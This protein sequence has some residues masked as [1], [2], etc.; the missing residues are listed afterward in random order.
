VTHPESSTG[1]GILL[2]SEGGN[3]DDRQLELRDYL[4][5]LVRRK[6]LIGATTL[7]FV[8]LTLVFSLLQD[9]VYRAVAEFE[10][11]A[12]TAPELPEGASDVAMAVARLQSDEIA[13]RARDG[14][15]AAPRVKAVPL[16]RTQI[17]QVQV[18]SGD[19]NL[20]ARAA[21]SYATEY[22][23]DR[24]DKARA[25]VDEAL[26]VVQPRLEAAKR[27]HDEIWASILRAPITQRD[28]LRQRYSVELA[29]LDQTIRD[30]GAQVRELL[31]KREA[32]ERTWPPAH[33]QA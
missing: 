16:A 8:A 9:P 18:E 6:W 3:R 21:N 32:I 7:V 33:A 2:V 5:V 17:I 11:P 10:L 19:P 20:A 31:S 22:L 24:K 4:A 13:T 28:P 25:R 23:A 14:L 1:H 15:G 30:D 27:R 29:Q 26:I 12:A